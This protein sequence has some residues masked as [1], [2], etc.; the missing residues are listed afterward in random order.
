MDAKNTA[1][2]QRTWKVA[3]PKRGPNKLPKKMKA[4]EEG[5]DHI[6]VEGNLFWD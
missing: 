6:V 1:H 2:T 5:K 4:R 3:T